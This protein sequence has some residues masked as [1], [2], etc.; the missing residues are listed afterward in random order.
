[1]K[2]QITFWLGCNVLRHGDIVHTCVEILK[3]LDID[4]VTVGGPNYCCGTVRHANVTASGGMG[5]RNASK[6]NDIGREKVVA[7]CPACYVQTD[8]FTRKFNETDFTLSHFT[9]LLYENRDNLAKMLTVPVRR[10]VVLH[11]HHGP[12]NDLPVNSMVPEVLRLIPDLDLVD[13][14]VLAPSYMC[15]ELSSVTEAM[16]DVV[17]NAVKSV[18]DAEADTLV[19]IHHPCQAQLCVLERSHDFKVVNYVTLLAESMGLSYSDDYKTWRNAEGDVR[20]V[21]GMERIQRAGPD[22][23]ERTIIPELT[24][25]SGF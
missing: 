1:M 9:S 23:F 13:T 14:D 8:R 15:A 22:M 17:S 6:L 5:T 4:A 12:G 20:G 24:E 25:K 19:T 2:D 18:K 21:I 7:W 11:K 16:A 3:R 10:R